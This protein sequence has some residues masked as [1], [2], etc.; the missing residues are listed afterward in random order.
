VD[1]VS[2]GGNLLSGTDQTFADA[3]FGSLTASFSYD[4]VAGLGQI[5]YTYSLLRAVGVPGVSADRILAVS[6]T[7]ADGDNAEAPL[8]ITVV[9]DSPNAIGDTAS[10]PRTEIQAVGNVIT[11]A[12]AGSIADIKGADGAVVAGL[13]RGNTGVDLIDPNTIGLNHTLQGT[14][15]GLL[16]F[17]NGSYQYILNSGNTPGGSD[18]FTYTIVDGDG[19]L[20][21]AELQIS[22]AGGVHTGGVATPGFLLVEDSGTGSDTF[23]VS[24][25]SQLVDTIHGTG[26]AATTDTLTLDAAGTYNLAASD[27]THID[28]VVL[29]ANA[30]GSSIIVG[31][32]VVST[33][34]FN[35]DGVG[36]DLQIS[37][38]APLSSGITIDASSLTASNHI[39]VDGLNFGGDDSLKGGAGDD[40]LAGGKGSDTLTGGAGANHFQYTSTLDGGTFAS[41]AGADHIVDF[42]AAKGDVID[43][44]GAAFGNLAPGT[45]VA[46]IFGNSA[47]DAFGSS[48][49]RFHYNT[50]SHTL[51]YDSNG[52]G[53]GGVQAA[54]AVFDNHAIVAATNIHVV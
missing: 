43:I 34:D 41:P 51:L 23:I 42:N 27:I 11:G 14:F 1:S 39:V 38:S 31:D 2:L 44:L 53:A 12:G 8:A 5:T 30:A 9:D 49:E 18:I 24:S 15:G 21:H 48:A 35:K 36:G 37:S 45:N 10:V 22:V 52:S 6:V 50:E 26:T 54:L 28:S 29:S 33:A 16:M 7:D 19:D 25:P 4:A 47:S 46:A 20:S 17:S 3:T 32:A 40:T 13:A